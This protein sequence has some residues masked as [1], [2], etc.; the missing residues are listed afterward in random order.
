MR[1]LFLA[2]IGG[3]AAAIAVVWLA[4]VRVAGQAQKSTAAATAAKNW[5]APRTVWGDP[6]LQGQWN[7]QT[8]TPLERPL[9]GALAQKTDLSEEEAETLESANRASVDEA[10]R[11]GD[12]GTYNAFWRDYGK[13]LKRTSLIV[14]PPDGRIPPLTPE[15][16][17]RIAA[18]RADRATRGPN[19]SPDTYTDLSPWTRCIS[20]GWNG[21]G[22]WYSSNYQI[23]QTQGYVVVLQELIHE[24]RIIPLDGRSHIPQGIPQWMGDSRGHWDGDTL[25]VETT[26]FDPRTNYQGSRETLHL[27]ERYTRVGPDTIDY[28]FTVDDPTTFTRPWTAMRPAT[29][30]KDGISIFEYACHE[31]NYAMGGILA[32]ARAADKAAAQIGKAKQ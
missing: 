21:I 20:R 16:K 32:G 7:S 15:A 25:V 13:P 24:P 18:E 4:P 11:A 9:E 1:N 26:N 17:K 10:P 31:G 23:F 28:Q 8:S 3:L 14:D 12:P 5:K 27:I 29:R 6:D 30:V 2:S 22:S 19:D